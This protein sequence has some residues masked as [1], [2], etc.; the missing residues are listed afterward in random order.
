MLIDEETSIKLS[1][2]NIN[3]YKQHFNNIKVGDT[4]IVNV[5][6]L[7]AGSNNTVRVSCDVCG[8]VK[9][10]MYVKYKKYVRKDGNYYC[11]KCKWIKIKNTKK[12]KYGDEN[13]NNRDKFKKTCIEEFGQDNPMKNEI[14]R[15][16]NKETCIEK[17]GHENVFQ[18]NDI[19]EKI[20][21]TNIK[22]YG[23]V[24]AHM[25]EIVK[26]KNKETL[27][28]KYNCDSSFKINP[29]DIKKKL[30]DKY[31]FDNI[32]KNVEIK[33]DIKEKI[34]K[35]WFN[36]I[37][38]KYNYLNFISVDFDKKEFEIEC[39]NHSFNISFGL[40]YNRN[41]ENYK[42]LLCTVCNPIND[43]DSGMENEMGRY[44]K[45][46]YNGDVLL[47]SN[48]IIKPYEIDI[49]LPKLKIGFEFNGIYWHSNIYK[50][51]NYHKLKSDLS[52]NLGIRLVQIYDDEWIFDKERV[53]NDI[54]K[55]LNPCEDISPTDIIIHEDYCE[56]LHSY[57]YNQIGLK[58]FL[59]N[60]PKNIYLTID[61]S[62]GIGLNL[63][64]L[65]FI[66]T[67]R[68]DPCCYNIIN[69]KRVVGYSEDYLNIYDSGNIIFKKFKNDFLK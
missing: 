40:F 27:L 67:K 41:R 9:E 61:R 44:I 28:K 51:K 15:N 39:K 3:Y 45:E 34:R 53:K 43:R 16:K 7:Y 5:N 19:K 11:E 37:K 20:K 22:K 58:K 33:K 65:G 30:V 66:E 62:Y 1:S 21:K 13:Y 18:S 32:F 47:R 6:S 46:I 29:D 64:D 10:M 36:D 57:R 17:H 69:N 42:T 55:I 26:N 56:L 12:E 49:F 38:K 4:I 8:E 52:D 63:K 23:F 48:N 2:R 35:N 24:H 50:D 25:S 59:K 68:T 14:V 31:G 54:K 60:Y